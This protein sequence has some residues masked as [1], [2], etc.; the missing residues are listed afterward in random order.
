MYTFAAILL[1]VQEV[2]QL[3]RS[4]MANGH[5]LFAQYGLRKPY[6]PSRDIKCFLMFFQLLV[7][8][9]PLTLV[10]KSQ[11]DEAGLLNIFRE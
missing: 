11:R 1:L 9:F 5:S 7:T 10:R 6:N 4:V 8:C 2:Q 3:R